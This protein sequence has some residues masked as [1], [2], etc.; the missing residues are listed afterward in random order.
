[1]QCIVGSIIVNNWNKTPKYAYTKT[2]VYNNV[3]M[4][5]TLLG[6]Y[7]IIHGIFYWQVADADIIKCS[8]KDDFPNKVFMNAKADKTVGD[9]DYLNKK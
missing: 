3:F 4:T 5:E 6:F 1:M 9:V 2:N 8:I 7:Q